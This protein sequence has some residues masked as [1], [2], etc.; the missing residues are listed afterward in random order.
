MKRH[1]NA[2]LAATAALAAHEQGKYFEFREQLYSH[3]EVTPA[4]VE[5]AAQAAGIELGW[6][7]AVISSGRFHWA[8]EA[9]IAEAEKALQTV[10][11]PRNRGPL[12][13]L[14]GQVRLGSLEIG[15]LRGYVRQ[16]LKTR[17]P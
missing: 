9:D 10:G 1:P 12:W 11:A 4:T 16:E 15:I 2:R 14:N 8:L 17:R 13:L 3:P 5:A 7:R 6:F